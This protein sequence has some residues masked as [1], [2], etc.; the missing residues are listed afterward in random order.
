MLVNLRLILRGSIYK[1]N[2]IGAHIIGDCW[3]FC[4]QRDIYR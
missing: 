4:R 3:L 2:T 1:A